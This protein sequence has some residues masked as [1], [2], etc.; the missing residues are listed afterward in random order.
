MK[1]SQIDEIQ[2]ELTLIVGGLQDELTA[3]IQAQEALKHLKTLNLTKTHLLRLLHCFTFILNTQLTKDK[4]Q[5]R[6][7][8]EIL[9]SFDVEF[10]V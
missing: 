5:K 7:I 2:E 4:L 10:R 8:N 9:K 6:I 1:T 3:E